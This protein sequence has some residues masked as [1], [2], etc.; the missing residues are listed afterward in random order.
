MDLH[1]MTVPA[2]AG[3]ARLDEV[4]ALPRRPLAVLCA[5]GR[6]RAIAPGERHGHAVLEGRPAL[7]AGTRVVVLSADVDPR[8]LPE[9]L[10]L[11]VLW[12]D[13]HLLVVSKPAGMAT[14]PGAKHPAGTLANALRGFGGQLS[15]VEG[16]LRPG[17][18]HRLDLGTSGAMLVARTDEVHVALVAAF[19]AH[20]VS[21]RYVAVVRG[22]PA[23]DELVAEGAIGRRRRD[24]RAY[25][26]VATGQPARTRLRVLRRGDGLAVVVAEPET[27][28]TH[29][30]RVHL[31]A[32]GHPLVGDTLYGG[33]A[34][35][36]LARTLG[37][38]RPA[39][40]AAVIAF[41]HPMTDKR[42]KAVAPLPTDLLETQ[43]LDG[44][45]LDADAAGATSG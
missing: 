25:G 10:P 26:V 32:A 9:D 23:W 7:P 6:V 41:V 37:L 2:G 28:R 33:A 42:V 27:G 8:L 4:L 21:R 45:S 17:I 36:H 38:A 35:R 39:L 15:T 16:S 40:H 22:E 29:Q 5:T 44:L 11:A 13:E 34:A 18:V 20:Q 3:G 19:A 31:A 24:R 12:Q 1:E 14:C 30:V 43:L